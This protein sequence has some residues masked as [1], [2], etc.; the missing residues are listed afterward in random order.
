MEFSQGLSESVVTRSARLWSGLALFGLGELNNRHSLQTR[1]QKRFQGHASSKQKSPR[2]FR[3]EGSRGEKF[4]IASVGDSARQGKKQYNEKTRCEIREESKGL[5][6]SYFL[7]WLA[8]E[9]RGVSVRQPKAES[10][11]LSVAFANAWAR[12]PVGIPVSCAEEVKVRLLWHLWSQF[13]I[14]G[15]HMYSW[16]TG[17]CY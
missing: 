2:A 3:K 1:A 16:G 5:S 7:P 11:F 10:W 9:W 13:S 12:I 15:Q 8:G 14:E 17:Q 4:A 6:W